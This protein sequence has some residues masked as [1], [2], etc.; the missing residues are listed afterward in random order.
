V[1]LVISL[2][3]DALADWRETY[4]YDISP[5]SDDAPFFWHFTS[6][7]NAVL[8]PPDR[9]DP[10]FDP[11]DA[12]GERVLV[13]L[14]L[15]VTLFAGVLLLLPLVAIRD[16]W[17]RMPHKRHA[18]AYFA[19]LGLGFMF[20]EISMIQ[21]FTLFLGY[22]AYSLTIT[23]FALLVFS[24]IGSLLSGRYAAHRDRALLALLA[25]LAALTLFYQFGIS[26]LVDLFIGA[27]LAL[28]A[29]LSLACLAPLGLCLGAFMPLGLGTVAALTPHRGQYVAWAWAVNGFFSVMSSVL[30]TMLSMTFGF[31]WVLFLALVIYGLGVATLT[32]IPATRPLRAG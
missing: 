29:L 18:L 20:F 10:I 26:W 7:R 25:G 1:Q 24:G 6:F 32:R 13:L 4:P 19:A 22:P 12:K 31:R 27:P 23:L 14:L 15:F 5:V 21:K 11:E 30:A 2:P 8:D 9:D 3:P 17:Y 16:V 28:R